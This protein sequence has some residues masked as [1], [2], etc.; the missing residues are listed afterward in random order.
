MT[1]QILSITRKELNIYFGSPL[2]F[3]F[4]GVFLAARAVHI[5]YHRHFLCQRH[6]RCQATFPVDAR[7]AHL[8]NCRSDHAPME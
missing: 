7:T 4:L 3:I 2:A 5:L 8:P 1:R 6:R